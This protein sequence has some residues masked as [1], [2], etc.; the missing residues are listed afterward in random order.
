MAA[1]CHLAGSKAQSWLCTFLS[2]GDKSESWILTPPEVPLPLL[3][4]SGV[5]FIA[6]PLQQ[7]REPHAEVAQSHL[8]LS[9]DSSPL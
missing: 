7:P 9:D 1:E 3:G 4:P 5:R 2:G 6:L 8:P